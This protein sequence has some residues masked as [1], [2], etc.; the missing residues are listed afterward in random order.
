[1]FTWLHGDLWVLILASLINL[2]C[3]NM[4]WRLCS[5][6]PPKGFPD[7]APGWV[8]WHSAA[9]FARTKIICIMLDYVPNGRQRFGH[10]G[11]ALLL[12]AYVVPWFDC[13]TIVHAWPGLGLSVSAVARGWPSRRV[14][15]QDGSMSRRLWV[16]A[17]TNAW[18]RMVAFEVLGVES[19]MFLCSLF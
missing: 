6:P 8:D 19:S 3:C 18:C 9:P 15:G 17:T 2:S 1:M 12:V 11:P 14:F 5:P 4:D 7:C 13:G 16:P 10:S